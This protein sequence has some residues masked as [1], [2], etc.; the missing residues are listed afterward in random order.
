LDTKEELNQEKVSNFA[1]QV[2][3]VLYSPLMAFKEIGKN[4]NIKGPLLI[5]I[6]TLPVSVG[7]ECIQSSKIFIETKMPEKD[8]WTE[9]SFP[10][11]SNGVLTDDGADYLIGNSSVSSSINGTTL[12]MNLTGL[13]G[14]NCSAEEN[15]RLSL[16]MKVMSGQPSAANITL[17]TEN[18]GGFE[19][20]ILPVLNETD[21]WI[22]TTIE[23]HSEN[24]VKYQSADWNN[25]I[26]GIGFRITW[27]D[28]G[29]YI[30]KIDGLFFGKFESPYSIYGFDMIVWLSLFNSI[31]N[32]L[33]S[34]LIFAGLVLLI[35]RSFS[36]WD[37]TFQYL[38]SYVG[39]V[40]A[41]FPVFLAITAIVSL[42]FPSLYIPAS[43]NTQEY[44]DVMQVY[45]ISW[46]TLGLIA[47]LI[48]YGW[49]TILGAISLKGLVDFSWGKA[50]LAGF[51][52]YIMSVLF[53]S[54]ILS[55][56]F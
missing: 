38:I 36:S 44:F 37:G 25:N 46:V 6:L 50:L 41:A 55:A 16:S 27:M 17:Y 1:K 21:T 10:W 31:A 4:P 40:F 35:L 22:N 43:I 49:I 30:V 51:G 29:D 39:Y 19:L 45:Q 33:V 5:L 34:W 42:S 12:L 9:S 7:V 18:I 8:A 32:F 13:D 54:F 56:L 20:D 23:L 28:P 14:V 3:K 26:T 2:L 52:T 15:T 48:Y 11:F 24:W 53:S 47:Q